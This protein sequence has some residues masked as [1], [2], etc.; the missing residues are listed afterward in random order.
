MAQRLVVGIALGCLLSA[1][2]GSEAAR[3]RGAADLWRWVPPS[4]NALFWADLDGFRRSSLDD[5]LDNDID[6]MRAVAEEFGGNMPGSAAS[7]AASEVLMNKGLVI[8]RKLDSV[9]IAVKTR[10]TPAADSLVPPAATPPPDESVFVFVA[11][12]TEADLDAVAAAARQQA[13]AT[14]ASQ[15][16]SLVGPATPPPVS[17]MDAAD[18]NP[19]TGGGGPQTDQ[20]LGVAPPPLPPPPPAEPFQRSRVG[21]RPG[22]SMGTT[23]LLDVGDGVWLMGERAAVEERLRAP[24]G[25]HPDHPELLRN[26]QDLGLFEQTVAFVGRQDSVSE[27]GALIPASVSGRAPWPEVIGP[28]DWFALGVQLEGDAHLRLL[29]EPTNPSRLQATETRLSAWRERFVQSGIAGLV[30]LREAFADAHVSSRNE[31]VELA[32]DIDGED[33]RLAYA[34]VSGLGVAVGVVAYVFI[35]AMGSALGSLGAG[36]GDATEAAPPSP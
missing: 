24:A 6:S 3:P 35:A 22:W 19:D 20:P 23:V 14:A 25:A 15:P 31:R 27:A 34:R 11:R 29:V 28:G 7:S 17:T 36:L 1:C 18:P 13:A 21:G 9:L 4:S 2:A 8:W 32:A 12:W 33:A 26:A 30:Y 5:L 16:A 10:P